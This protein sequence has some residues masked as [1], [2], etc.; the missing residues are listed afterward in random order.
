MKRILVVTEVFW[1]ENGLVNDFV[2]ELLDR[3]YRV[4]VLTQHPSYPYGRIYPGYA[5]VHYATEQWHGATIHRFPLVEGYRESKMRKILNY[6]TFVRKG[7]KLARRIGADYDHVVVYQTGPLTV[8]LPGVEVKRRYGTPLTVWTFD[9]WPDAVY[10]YG[11]PRIFPL[12]AFLNRIIR[13]VYRAADH[14]LVSS[15]AFAQIVGPYVPGRDIVYA[16]NWLTGGDSQEPS[17]LQ[18]DPARFHFTFAG[19]ISISQNLDKVLIAWKKAGLADADLDIVGDGSALES[20][21]KQVAEQ[22]I[23][24]VCFHGRYP[25]E[26]MADILR[27]SDALVLSLVAD[28]GVG[29][30]EPF[31]L[32]SYLDAGKPIFGV[33][34][35]PARE[36]IEQNRLGLCARPDDVSQIARQFSQ[37]KDFVGTS[38]AGVAERSRALLASRFD[39]QKTL[40]KVLACI[41]GA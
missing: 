28:A 13:T 30:T 21:K 8:A 19:N 18:F 7:K 5:N 38:G 26:Q 41:E 25:A 24:N 31:K 35:G 1:P 20:L 27:R 32:Q 3:G 36:M 9:I 2:L 34:D 6:W 15:Q 39:K 17:D 22:G 16:P 37:M 14:I 11:F 4:D 40:G 10:A 29:C 33:I 23:E 12:T